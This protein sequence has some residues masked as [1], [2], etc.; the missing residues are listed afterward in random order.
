MSS[1]PPFVSLLVVAVF[2]PGIF[3]S[4]WPQ[5]RGQGATGVSDETGLV[6][7]W[8]DRENIIWKCSL[9]GKGNSSPI[10]WGDHI[11]LTA[12]SGRELFVVCIDSKTGK[13]LW[14]KTAPEDRRSNTHGW[15]GFASPT[16][17]TDGKRVYASF[18]PT[19]VV[20]YDFQGNQ[21]WRQA[22][23]DFESLN[24][25]WGAASSPCIDDGKLYISLDHDGQSFVAA[26][27]SGTGKVI[28]STQRKF[29]RGYASPVLIETDA[30]RELVINGHRRVFAYDPDNGKELWY[31]WGMMQ[32]VNPTVVFAHG[33]VYAVSGRDGPT[34]AIKPGGKKDVTRSGVIWR[35][36]RG[37]PYIPSPIVYGDYFYMTNDNGIVT[38]FDART[39]K[40]QFQGRLGSRGQ[41]SASPAAADG[42]IYFLSESGSCT[43]IQAGP[44]LEVLSTNQLSGQLFRASPAISG[45]RIYIRSQRILYCIGK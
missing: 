19:G 8:N 34:V 44:K 39:G 16:P 1:I 43:V 5:W 11:F 29:P 2:S 30:G 20:A 15:N 10:V 33:L 4:N 27:N 35:A 32:W 13:I 9:P 31:C 25:P 45:G 17:A 41:H 22:L 24:S 23:G 40:Q 6:S 7:Q 14:Q 28:W 37:A 21:S 18:Q 36:N 12:E 26:L 38:C 42:K 3:A